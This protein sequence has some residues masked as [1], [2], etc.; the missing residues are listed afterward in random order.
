MQIEYNPENFVLIFQNSTWLNSTYC[1][2]RVSCPTNKI[3]E[4]TTGSICDK[5]NYGDKKEWVTK[6]IEGRLFNRDYPYL[7]LHAGNVL[8]YYTFS[9]K[10]FTPFYDN[11]VA[12]KIMHEFFYR[13][14]CLSDK[15]TN[16]HASQTM[17]EIQVQARDEYYDGV[18]ESSNKIAGIIDFDDLYEDSEE[19]E[20]YVHILQ[21]APTRP[22]K[23]K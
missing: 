22:G 8:G 14:M 6:T 21:T 17:K 10:N 16:W 20:E 5:T 9:D 12:H 13:M 1:F 18:Y 7:Y 23:N 19:E 2:I 15:T 3:I 4:L 11:G